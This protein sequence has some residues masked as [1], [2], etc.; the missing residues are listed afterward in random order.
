MKEARQFVRRIVVSVLATIVFS[1]LTQAQ[2]SKSAP[3]FEIT[4]ETSKVTFYVK[5][6]VKLEGTFDKWDATLVFTSTDA[7]TGVLDIKIL[8]DSVRSDSTS[9]ENKLKGEHCFDVKNNPY[10]AFHS[11]KITQTSPNAFGVAGIVADSRRF[12]DGQKR[13][14]RGLQIAS[15]SGMDGEQ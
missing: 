1:T 12:R 3:V 10:V 2:S 9:K 4:P 5:A 11:T 6:S 7:S 14:L 15:V 13:P 8:A